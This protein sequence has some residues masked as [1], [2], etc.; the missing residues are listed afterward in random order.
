MT[1]APRPTELRPIPSLNQVA[2]RMTDRV[3]KPSAVA[4]PKARAAR[5]RP[6]QA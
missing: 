2:D 4:K 3:T 5:P 1:E 6:K